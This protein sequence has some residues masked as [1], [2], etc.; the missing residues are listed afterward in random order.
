VT[1]PPAYHSDV[2]DKIDGLVEKRAALLY[3]PSTK[4]NGDLSAS[5]I[6]DTGQA[7][8]AFDHSTGSPLK[9]SSGVITNTPSATPSAGYLQADL[10]SQVRRIGAMVSW[11]L[12]A[13]GV[14]GLVLPS[15]AW[16]NASLDPPAGFHLVLGGNGNWT[17]MRYDAAGGSVTLATQLTHGKFDSATWGTGYK[18]VDVWVSPEDQRAVITW[19]DGTSSTITSSYFDTETDRYAIWELFSATGSDVAASLGTL[20]ADTAPTTADAS[21]LTSY[22]MPSVQPPSS[23]T[24]SGIV[25]VEPLKTNVQ[26]LTLTGNITSL[27]V[28]LSPFPPNGHTL[29]LHFVQDGT[30]SR[31]LAGVGSTLKFAGAAAPTLTTTANRRDIFRFRYYGGTYYE[32]SRSMNVG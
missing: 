1:W 3:D 15:A 22:R 28:S 19:P 12:N 9:I 7:M 25:A 32:A 5:L 10:G 27:T 11:P 8:T 31:T 29:E 26:L 24:A 16:T 2:K 17:L 23:N 13:A 14:V 4:T 20:W 30:G 18:P 6:A 21:V